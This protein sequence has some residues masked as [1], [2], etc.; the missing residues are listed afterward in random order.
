MTSLSPLVGVE[1]TLGRVAGAVRQFAEDLGAPVVG[2]FQIC[3]SDEVE[4]ETAEAFDRYFVR[5]LLPAL[6]GDRRAA[7]LLANLGA[8]YEWGA[9]RIAEEHFATATSRHAYKLL[10]VKLNTHVA[11]RNTPEGPV[12]GTLNRYGESSA[13]CGALAAVFEQVQ[14]P[15][16][17]ELR[18]QFAHGD[19]RRLEVLGDPGRVAPRY[20]ALFTAI[21]GAWLQAGRV[22]LDVR[23][24]RPASPTMFVVLPCVTINRADDLDTELL[25]GQ[26]GI[27]RTGSEIA[28]K[29]HGLGGD[30]ARYRARHEQGRLV[31]VEEEEPG[32]A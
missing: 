26:Y 15:A 24:F 1:S 5:E 20:R 11:V 14:L 31:V 30:P 4:R 32:D 19:A 23:E 2:G 12:Y 17:R 3:C 22:V 16:I 25:V 18:E 28:A 21:T 27:D 9:L 29:Y 6:K 8:R 13:C 10:V 7:F